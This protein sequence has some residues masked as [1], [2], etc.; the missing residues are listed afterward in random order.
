MR[1]ISLS[2]RVYP[3]CIY[4]SLLLGYT[5]GVYTPPYCITLG[6]AQDRQKR[7]QLCEKW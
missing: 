4:A 2:L 3:G 5:Q 7:Q 6:Y 1:L